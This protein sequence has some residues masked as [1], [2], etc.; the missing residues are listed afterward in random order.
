MVL[1][2]K[3][4]PLGEQQG[5]KTTRL[6]KTLR[7]R[8]PL[9]H[10][11]AMPPPIDS[12]PW[13]TLLELVFGMKTLLS[14]PVCSF[15][16]LKEKEL[17]EKIARGELVDKTKIRL[18]K[19]KT[20]LSLLAGYDQHSDDD[21]KPSRGYKNARGRGPR[22]RKNFRNRDPKPKGPL[23]CNKFIAGYCYAGDKCKFVHDPLKR[24]A[25][26][27]RSRKRDFQRRI[28]NR[29]RSLLYKVS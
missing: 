14:T 4:S 25:A 22:G 13:C 10:I 29:Q 16:S 26:I 23:N 1:V 19:K 27:K 6:P 3:R 2:L 28:T 24:R 9:S 21:Q 5:G 18:G 17:A 8:F 11:V 20:S 12:N 7:E 15:C